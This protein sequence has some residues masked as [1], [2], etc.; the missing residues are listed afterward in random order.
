MRCVLTIAGFDPCGGAGLQADLK[1]ISALGAYALTAL[2]S[3]TAQ[4]TKEIRTMQYIEPQMLDAQLDALESDL[5]IDAVKIGMLGSEGIVRSVISFLQRARKSHPRLPVVID[6]LMESSSGCALLSEEARESLINTLLPLATV[7][8]PNIPEAE[9]I[10]GRPIKEQEDMEKACRDL[11]LLG[12]AWVVLKGGHH[13]GNPIDV[14]GHANE[15]L[16]YYGEKIPGAGY[17]G[18]GCTFASA[19]AVF[20]AQGAPVPEAVVK[21]KRYVE[22]AIKGAFSPGEGAAILNHFYSGTVRERGEGD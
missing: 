8:T 20:I 22:G 14:L 6:P 13:V 5:P 4:N 7:L 10:L 16:V 9:Y 18:T 11:G 19:L 21:A 12:P 2:T 17:H 1:T 15:I 3:V